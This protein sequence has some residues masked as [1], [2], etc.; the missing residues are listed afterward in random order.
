MTIS[1]TSA[2]LFLDCRNAVWSGNNLAS[3]IN[4][5]VDGGSATLPGVP[6]RGA[7]QQGYSM[8]QVTDVSQQINFALGAWSSGHISYYFYGKVFGGIPGNGVVGNGWSGGT[9][10][11]AWYVST[12]GGTVFNFS[13]NCC[14]VDAGHAP[15]FSSTAMLTDTNMHKMAA[16]MDTTNTYYIDGVSQSM[17]ATAG[18]AAPNYGASTWNIGCAEAVVNNNEH[19]N[20]EIFA[21]CIFDVQLSAGDVAD[22]DKFF[23]DIGSLM[24]QV[25]M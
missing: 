5:G 6:V 18:A 8:I 14:S 20:G 19:L 21:V 10:A 11:R 12:N 3:I 15:S 1:P 2:R 22:L 17:S 7:T 9:N 24:P 25:V 23:S 4:S 16:V 13:N